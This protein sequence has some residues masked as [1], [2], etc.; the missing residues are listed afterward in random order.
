VAQLR[1]AGC[2]FAEDE[3]VVLAEAATSPDELA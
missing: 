3:A 1:A 2:V